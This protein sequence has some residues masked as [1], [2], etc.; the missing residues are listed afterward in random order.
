M[1]DICFMFEVHQPFRLNR[2]FSADLLSR[3]QVTKEDLFELYFDNQLNQHVFERAARKCYYPTNSLIL[4][5]IDRFKKDTKKFKVAYSIS[6]VFIEQC[7]RWN[8]N[9]LES[10]RQLAKTGCV[11]FLDQTY[12]HSLS[13]LYSTERQEFIEQV[14]MH[15]KLTKDLLD[16]EPKIFENTECLYN[17]SIAKTVEALGYKAIVTEGVERILN[18]RSPNHVYK[19]KNS[20]LRVLMRNYRLSDD[21]GFRFSSHWWEE[22]P[23]TSNKY[24]SWLAG[25]QGQMILLFADY[26]TFGEH[27]WP[28]TGIHEFL[29]WLPQEVIKWK[30]LNWATPSE[31]VQWHEPVGEIDVHEYNTISWADLERDT[32]AWIGNSMQTICYESLKSLEPFVKG[33]NDE[34]LLRLWRYLQMSDH[35]YYMSIKG[36]GP[37]DVHSYFNP[38]GSPVEAFAMYSRILS[39]LEARIM[40]ELQKPELTAKRLLRQLPAEKG[41]TFF[42]MFARPT[43]QAVHSLKEFHAALSI[44]DIKS[45]QF[46]ME[47]GDFARWIRQVVGDEKLADETANLSHKKLIGE[48]LRKTILNI[49]KNRIIELEQ[50]AAKS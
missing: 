8:P 6:G 35:Y 15:R 44:V 42:T 39:D 13:S 12:Y 14:Q 4:E 7:E 36:G 16:Y 25:N 9:L 31:I 46:H 30:H 28:E 27:Q 43:K 41:F 45:I 40:Q 37:G 11:E 3:K 33:I 49:V 10:F 2:N 21:I 29:R 1:L 48:S 18:W 24:A 50:M 38:C 20:N 5:Q 32:T 26:E 23:L 22:W 17:N 47:R 19:A 34:Q